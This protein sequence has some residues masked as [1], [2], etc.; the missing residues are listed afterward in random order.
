MGGSGGTSPEE[1]LYGGP[2]VARWFAE[3]GAKRERWDAPA[4]DGESPEAEWGFEERL[5]ADVGGFAADHGYPMVS[6]CFDEPEGPSPLVAELYRWWYRA[7]GL[8]AERLLVDSFILMDPWWTLRLGAVPFW[9]KFNTEGS[10][11]A[12]E[13]HLDD[14]EP[15]DEIR[16]MLF[17]HG[18]HSIGLTPIERWRA[19]LAR[20]RRHGAFV[21][22]DERAYPADFAVFAR[23]HPALRKIAGRY[24]LVFA[25]LNLQV[26]STASATMPRS[27]AIL[28]VSSNRSPGR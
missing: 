1:Y 24:P 23:Y 27:T 14:A 20:A 28:S 8:P 13:R 2:R 3:Q 5:R 15:Y 26:R 9:V 6:V 12:L 19:L 7:R 21:G 4:A 22:V 25:Q 18:V 11:A 17:A 10:A 16:L